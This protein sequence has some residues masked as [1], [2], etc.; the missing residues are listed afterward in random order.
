MFALLDTN[1]MTTNITKLLRHL[2]LRKSLHLIE[3]D[4]KN[5]QI[6]TPLVTLKDFD[7]N[8]IEKMKQQLIELYQNDHILKQARSQTKLKIISQASNYAN[9]Y[10]KPSEEPNPKRR[11]VGPGPQDNES[12]ESNE[13]P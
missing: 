10:K 13:K 9:E 12:N 1:Y 8:I 2:L 11:R 4:K 6:Q 3:K 7:N 5:I